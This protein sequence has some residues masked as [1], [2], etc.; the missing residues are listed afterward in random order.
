MTFTEAKSIYNAASMMRDDLPDGMWEDI[1]EVVAAYRES[2]KD[3]DDKEF[4]AEGIYE[5]CEDWG[6]ATSPTEFLEAI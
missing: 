2:D 1:L 3:E 4:F 5:A 6:F